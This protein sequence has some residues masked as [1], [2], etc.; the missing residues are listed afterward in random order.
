M[1]EYP[2]INSLYKR[3]MFVKGLPKGTH[4]KL[5]EGDYSCL[6]F[7]NIN[8]W[9][10]Q[11]KIDG[12]NIRINFDGENVRFGGRTDDAQI[13]CHLLDYLMK[14]FTVETIMEGLPLAKNVTFFGEGYG[15]KIQT[16]GNYRD[17]PG[18]I[19]FDVL[20]G[21]LWAQRSTIEAIAENMGVPVA[22]YI[23]I[24]TKESI[25]DLVKSKLQS[26]CSIKPQVMEGVVC[27][28]EPLMLFRGDRNPIKFKLKCKEYKND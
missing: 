18:F 1:I 21:G 28:S 4:G 11:E 6:E 26:L 14:Q 5:I 24:M 3:E 27:R 7:A 10:V 19:L 22:P 20:F 12:T 13:P 15:P 9:L 17:T 2:K 16:G 8:N 25:V 23:G